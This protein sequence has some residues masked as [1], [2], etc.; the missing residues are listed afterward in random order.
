MKVCCT[1]HERKPLSEFN[2]RRASP[3]G[4]Q[5]RCRECSRVWYELNRKQ[6]II[7]ARRR[8][9]GV[10][11]ANRQRLVA[12]FREHPCVDCGETDIRVL[13]FD[14]RPHCVKVENIARLLADGCAWATIAAEIKKCDVRCANCHRIKTI[15]RSKTWRHASWEASLKIADPRD[16]IAEQRP[17]ELWAAS[18]LNREPED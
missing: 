6:H 2:K 5:A 4:L 1:C 9:D 18:D 12:Y 15:E 11:E 3:D 14:H 10:R 13:E 8:T 7:N 17:Q 16:V